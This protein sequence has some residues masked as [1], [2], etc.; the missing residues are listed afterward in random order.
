MHPKALNPN[1]IWESTI[2]TYGLSKILQVSCHR[3]KRAIK[4]A[5]KCVRSFSVR[6]N[7]ALH[8]LVMVKNKS[9]RL[10]NKG[11]YHKGQS[12]MTFFCT[13]GLSIQTN[14]RMATSA[15][16]CEEPI[17]YFSVFTFM[18]ESKFF[19]YSFLFFSFGKHHVVRK[20]LGT[21]V[22]LN[23]GGISY[24]CWHRP[25]GE[26]VGRQN[27]KPLSFYVSSWNVLLMGTRWVLAIIEDY[28]M[29][30]YV[31][32]LLK[33]CWISWIAIAWWLRTY[34]VEFQEN[35]LFEP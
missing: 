31:E 15:S 3:C 22:Q 20:D 2:P 10:H 23:M 28:M 11:R 21:Y 24:Y 29:V 27:Y 8:E 34:V 6:E 19:L 25:W 13:K 5:S 17:F 16:L 9:D 18:Q 1:L 14:K 12:N 33:V 32:L 30:E 35:S 4:I 26:Y 7:W